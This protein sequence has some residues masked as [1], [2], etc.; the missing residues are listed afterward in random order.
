MRCGEADGDAALGWLR[1]PSLLTSSF[2]TELKLS[3]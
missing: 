3:R 1:K 2:T